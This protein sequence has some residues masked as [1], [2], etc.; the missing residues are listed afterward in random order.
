VPGALAINFNSTFVDDCAYPLGCSFFNASIWEGGVVPSAN[1]DV[2]ITGHWNGSEAAENEVLY[3]HFDASS[4]VTSLKSLYVRSAAVVV[5]TNSTVN[6]NGSVNLDTYGSLYTFANSTLTT[7][8]SLTVVDSAWLYVAGAASAFNAT[9]LGGIRLHTTFQVVNV[10]FGSFNYSVLGFSGTNSISVLPSVTFSLTGVQVGTLNVATNATVNLF[11][12]ATINQLQIAVNASVTTYG[13]ATIG[14]TSTAAPLSGS[15]SLYL[16]EIAD[17]YSSLSSPAFAGTV[18][19]DDVVVSLSNVTLNN[20]VFNSA[21]TTVYAR[22]ATLP[23]STTVKGHLGVINSVLTVAEVFVLGTFSVENSTLTVSS[24]LQITNAWSFV[25]ENSQLNLGGIVTGNLT[26]PSTSTLSV[27]GTN[28]TIFGQ[29]ENYGSLALSGKKP[30]SVFG[31]AVLHNISRVSAVLIGAK[32]AAL[33]VYGGS[34]NVAGELVYNVEKKPVLKSV[35]YLVAESINGTLNGTFNHE[36]AKAVSGSKI[37]RDLPI[38]YGST[39]ITVHY[40]WAVGDTQWWAWLILG[41]GIAV[42]LGIVIGI[43]VR[44]RSRRANYT[45]VR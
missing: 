30:L 18:Y 35:T 44:I 39:K 23:G 14:T 22:G 34:L 24:H 6:I 17:I 25:L 42:V 4:G 32:E 41:V 11:S 3:I 12:T 28:A 19:V 5:N 31:D 1:D 29:F 38:Q 27:S 26:I 2:N 21:N 43:V 20:L 37:T 7:G 9:L 36:T 10:V 40:K 33:I 45:P 15:G 8:A 13:P 16:E